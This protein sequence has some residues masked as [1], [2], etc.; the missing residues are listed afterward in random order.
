MKELVLIANVGDMS[1]IFYEG[2]NPKYLGKKLYGDFRNGAMADLSH[3]SR[4]A[5]VKLDEYR[6]T[7]LN[8][9]VSLRLRL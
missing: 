6:D 1:E 7:L 2:K 5:S 8:R 4:I 3:R 9:H